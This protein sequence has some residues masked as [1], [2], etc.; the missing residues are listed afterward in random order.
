MKFNRIRYISSVMGLS[1]FLTLLFTACRSGENATNKMT[2]GDTITTNSSL[3]TIIDFP[4]YT[5]VD[6]ENPW[7]RGNRM[8][9]YVLVDR[10]KK[11]QDLPDGILV[12]VP[13]RS[14]LVYSSVHAGAIKEI[15]K[16]NAVTAVCDAQYYKI[17]EIVE[18][19][20]SG[21]ITDVGASM[22]PTIEHILEHEPEAILTSPFQNAGHG[23]IEQLKIP[24]IECADY[25]ESTPLGRAEWIKFIGRLYGEAAKSDSIYKNVEEN[26]QTLSGKI[27][28]ANRP[29]VISEMVTD[30]VWY[31]PGGNSYMAQIFRD[32]GAD[33]PW[34]DDTSTGSLQ[35]DFATVYDKAHDADFWFIKTFDRDLTLD[36][37]KDNYPLHERMAAFG[38]GGVYSC[39]TA[40]SSFFEDFPFHPDLLLHDF[41]NILHPGVLSDTTLHYYHQVK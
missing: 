41:I 10:D 1:V 32:A 40:T 22:S 36:E 18:G 37:L 38:N 23:A 21:R 27:S 26:Y 15:G 39:N 4:D 28:D 14:S 8:Q 13:L 29:V 31:L 17:P 34:N 19:L 25:M 20:K 24:I 35:L 9:R 6:V 7:H 5:V 2:D 11:K 3:L 12:K 33:Y 30:G 16:I